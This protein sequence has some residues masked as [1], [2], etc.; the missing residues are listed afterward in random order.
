[1]KNAR[2]N[3]VKLE[4]VKINHQKIKLWNHFFNVIFKSDE[5][6]IAFQELE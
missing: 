1:M 5:I 4:R 6:S 2:F 3:E